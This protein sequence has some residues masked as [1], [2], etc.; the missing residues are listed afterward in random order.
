MVSNP[1]QHFAQVY[2]N[3]RRLGMLLVMLFTWIGEGRSH[4]SYMDP[5]QAIPYLSDIGA[6]PLKPL[7]ITGCIMTAIFVDC[8]FASER[9]LRHQSRLGK[10]T[11]TIDKALAV[12]TIVFAVIGTVGLIMLSVFDL[13][14][15]PLTHATFLML[16]MVGFIISGI[17][18][19]WEFQRLDTSERSIRLSRRVLLIF[20]QA[21]R[22]N[23]ILLIS[24]WAK[25][26]FSLVDTA[27]SV[28]K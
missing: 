16:A 23:K 17:F 14:H 19:C 8:A 6:G 24:F 11:T 9:W 7:F 25:L 3:G 28:G 26:A 18:M 2:A 20:L 27:L 12:L 10:K 21:Y 5:G 1:R 4:Y 22:Q 13:A 15:Y